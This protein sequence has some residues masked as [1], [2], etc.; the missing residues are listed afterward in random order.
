MTESTPEPRSTEGLAVA[1]LD[2]HFG[3]LGYAAMT[4]STEVAP[5]A[6]AR[7]A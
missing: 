2:H 4:R 1:A 6:R 3:A 7:A 5:G